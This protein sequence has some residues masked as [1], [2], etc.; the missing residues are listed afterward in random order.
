VLKIISLALARKR[1]KSDQSRGNQMWIEYV[2]KG[3][4]DGHQVFRRSVIEN[5]MKEIEAE[6]KP[7]TSSTPDIKEMK[8]QLE[9]SRK[10]N[11]ILTA[12]LARIR[13]IAEEN[14]D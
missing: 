4:A 10:T 2:Q 12:K 13:A 6:Y 7:L 14:K 9:R 8:D 1:Q 3:L 5:L 11:R